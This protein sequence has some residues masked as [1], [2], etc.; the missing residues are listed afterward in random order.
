MNDDLK[1]KPI[2]LA[3]A[4]PAFP[5]LNTQQLEIWTGPT[6]LRRSGISIAGI[7]RVYLD[8]LPF[9]EFLFEFKSDED[10]LKQAFLYNIYSDWEMECG[11]PIGTIKCGISKFQ[12]TC[13]GSV[14]DQD[15]RRDHE[16]LYT[17]AKF[18]VI[19]GPTVDGES[20]QIDS[21]PFHGRVSAKIGNCQV[22]VDP[23]SREKQER[24]HIYQPTHVVFC[25]FPEAKSLADI[26]ELRDDL[27]RTLSLI[28][29]RWVGLVGP[30][31]TS[32]DP[33]A[34]SFRLSVTKT[35][36]NGGSVS[37]YHKSA[38][39]CFAELAPRMFESFADSKRGEALRTALHWLIEAEQCAGG[40]EGSMILQ[41]SAL[42]CLS[43]L[44]IVID[45]KI[46]SHSKFD[47]LT[48]AEKIRKML[49]L[50]RIDIGIPKNCS[51][52]QSYANDGKL[53]DLV[54]VMVN[55]RNALVHADPKK[56]ALLFSRKQGSDE[57]T[58]LWYQTGGLLQQAFLASIGYQGLLRKREP[59]GG[60]TVDAVTPA[61]WV[62]SI[63]EAE[64]GDESDT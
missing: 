50:F 21:V 54:D 55:V 56:V 17:H 59:S 57:R 44:A 46:C 24:R 18:L 62:L 38:G 25:E 41:Q 58:E 51:S 13:S 5:N 20:I 32:D 7:G 48:A 52:I 6:L 8:M 12:G 40:V 37:W 45:R 36:R 61:P 42:E 64:S 30:W 16:P 53:T 63:T 33:Q 27:F 39:D 15:P 47:K 26:D 31:L 4:P 43:W 2:P 3:I 34:I 49:S 35:M 9:P 19:N 10:S 22:T 29:C 14:E 11:H 60:F 23:L 1:N 28:K